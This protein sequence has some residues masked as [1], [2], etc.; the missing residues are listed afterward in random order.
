MLIKTF[1]PKSDQLGTIQEG[2]R[3]E[4]LRESKGNKGVKMI[5]LTS[6]LVKPLGKTTHL[7]GLGFQR[8]GNIFI[9]TVDIR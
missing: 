6:G 4:R 1:F 9:N 5:V 2:Q 8:V 7:Y 3:R